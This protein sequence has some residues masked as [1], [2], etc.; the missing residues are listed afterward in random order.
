MPSIEHFF[1]FPHLSK[2]KYWTLLLDSVC[3]NAHMLVFVFSSGHFILAKCSSMAKS[4][5]ILDKERTVRR[6]E[7]FMFCILLYIVYILL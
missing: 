7:R 5:K 1:P 2:T 6:K 3:L 4:Q